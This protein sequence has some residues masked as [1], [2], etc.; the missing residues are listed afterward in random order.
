MCFISK[1]RY[2]EVG[3]EASGLYRKTTNSDGFITFIRKTDSEIEAEKEQ[4][5][6]EETKSGRGSFLDD[7]NNQE[8]TVDSQDHL[9]I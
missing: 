1:K 4:K 3:E 9:H 5:K 2:E 8:E 7:S 6:K